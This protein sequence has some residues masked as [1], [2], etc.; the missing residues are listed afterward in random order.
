MTQQEERTRRIIRLCVCGVALLSNG[1]NVFIAVEGGANSGTLCDRCQPRECFV[2]V[3]GISPTAIPPFA[4]SEDDDNDTMPA[5]SCRR[6]S[7]GS[8]SN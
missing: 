4:V 2:F 8:S 7:G 5:T 1:I 6:D 3:Y